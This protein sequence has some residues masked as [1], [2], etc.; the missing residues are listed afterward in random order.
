MM[1]SGTVLKNKAKREAAQAAFQQQA[2]ERTSQLADSSEN[3]LERAVHSTH[4]QEGSEVHNV[5]RPPAKRWKRASSLPVIEDRG[6]WHYRWCAI[7]G[8]NRGDQRG[9]SKRLQEGWEIVKPDELDIDSLPT[10]LLDRRGEVI[11]NGDMILMKL[12]EELLAQ[13]NEEYENRRD[14]TTA[15]LE[16]EHQEHSDPRMPIRRKASSRPEFIKIRKR[17]KVGSRRVAD[18]EED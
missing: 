7:D 13:R 4:R 10:Q 12:H 2:R 5:V 6:G 8:K 1:K 17:Q 15:A 18:D 11:G 3:R 14:V 16:T 9:V